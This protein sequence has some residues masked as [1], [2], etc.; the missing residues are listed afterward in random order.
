MSSM[1][2]LKN[3]QMFYVMHKLPYL[4][5]IPNIL[6][7]TETPSI[8]ANSV[9]SSFQLDYLCK[10]MLWCTA[11]WCS[12]DTSFHFPFFHV[13]LNSEN[14]LLHY[15]KLYRG[16]LVLTVLKEMQYFLLVQE[17]Y[18]PTVQDYYT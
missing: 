1:E 6:S 2:A 17:D 12:P 7:H 4:S 9:P 11:V 15:W 3:G 16:M 10:K 14:D 18:F 5:G 13:D 8:F